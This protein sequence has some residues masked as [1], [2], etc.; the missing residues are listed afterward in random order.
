MTHNTH[1][2]ALLLLLL[3][4]ER[5]NQLKSSLSSLAKH[6]QSEGLPPAECNVV[7][8]GDVNSG[9]NEAVYKLL[10]EG[11]LP[12]GDIDHEEKALQC[13]LVCSLLRCS[14]KEPAPSHSLLYNGDCNWD[15]CNCTAAWVSSL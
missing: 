5:I 3:L 13:G 9:R 8:A 11:W 10:S 14:R 12:A 7:V 15:P 6:Q 4:Q 1:N 2:A